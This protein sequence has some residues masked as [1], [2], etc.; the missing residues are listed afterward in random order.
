[1]VNQKKPSPLWQDLPI[2]LCNLGFPNTK[3][4]LISGE[5]YARAIT[6]EMMGNKKK[7][8]LTYRDRLL[9][10]SIAAEEK[11]RRLK[12]I[13]ENLSYLEERNPRSNTQASGDRQLLKGVLLGGLLT[14]FGMYFIDQ[15]K[16]QLK[17]SLS[18]GIMN[19]IQSEM[20]KQ[21]I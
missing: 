9:G 12:D 18:E 20:K 10:S 1:M 13:R 2:L 8:L 15:F 19:G 11:E 17:E 14:I 16:N 7:Q 5:E 4:C 6:P 3:N 21:R